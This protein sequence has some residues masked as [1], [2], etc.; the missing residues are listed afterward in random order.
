[1]NIHIRKAKEE[2]LPIVFGL[3]KEFAEYLGRSSK[4]KTSIED[5]K[6]NKDFFYCLLAETD[7]G[8]IT[9]Y[10][11]FCYSFHTWSGKAIYLDDLYVRDEYRRCQIGTKLVSAVIDFARKNACKT[12]R[13]EVINWNDKAISFYKKLGAVVGDENLNCSYAIR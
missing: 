13:W 11:L 3:I 12:L 5:F 2:D 7:D 9:G 4:V 1:M 10:A 8:D 6:R